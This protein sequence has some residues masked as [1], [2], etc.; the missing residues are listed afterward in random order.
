MKLRI[1]LCFA[2]IWIASAIPIRANDT[3]VGKDSNAFVISDK[4]KSDLTII[5]QTVPAPTQ[6]TKNPDP[7][8]IIKDVKNAKSW[9]D[10][11]NLEN[12]IYAFLLMIAGYLSYF[13]PGLRNIPSTTFRVLTFS[14]L[15]IAGVTVV[16]LADVWQ[17]IISYLLST[18]MYSIIFKWIFPNFKPPEAKI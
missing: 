12:A 4:V 2:L 17:G 5:K 14:V 8:Q 6:S 7:E 16:G 1:F 3:D 15:I 11:L 13:I 9:Q 10:L 18:G